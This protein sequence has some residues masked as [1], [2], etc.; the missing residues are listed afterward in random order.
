ME[1]YKRVHSVTIRS[2]AKAGAIAAGGVGEPNTC[3]LGALTPQVKT[4]SNL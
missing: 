4:G 1:F 2:R 3:S